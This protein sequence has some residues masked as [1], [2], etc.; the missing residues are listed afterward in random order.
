MTPSGTSLRK[1]R[2]PGGVVLEGNCNLSTATL[3]PLS[4]QEEEWLVCNRGIPSAAKV[5]WLLNACTVS[6]DDASAT[7]DLIRALLVG[8]RDYLM[9]QLRQLTFGDDFRAIASCM[10]CGGKIDVDFKATEIPVISRPQTDRFHVLGISGRSVQFRLPT[11]GDQEAV[12]AQELNAAVDEMLGRCVL[13]EDGRKMSPGEKDAVIRAME[14]LSPSIELEL[15]ITCPECAHTF[16]MPFDTTVFFLEEVEAASRQLLREVH[17][18][19]FHYHWS[20]ADILRLQRSR[21][22]T[23]LRFLDESLRSN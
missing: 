6:L 14:Q 1:T 17:A 2:L 10:N 5:T 15:D 18:L 9:L 22:H 4:G 20:E 19:A 7:S 13:N 16:L 23:Y 21:R 8:D 3:R 12:M 11:G